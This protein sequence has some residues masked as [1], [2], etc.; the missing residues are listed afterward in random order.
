MSQTGGETMAIDLSNIRALTF[1]V[2]GTVFD[3]HH[4]VRDEVQRLA[5]E[6]AVEVNAPQFTN[7]W[8]RSMFAQLGLVRSGEL[9]W[10]NADEMH[11]AALD[12]VVPRHT[13]DLSATERDELNRV[14]HRLRV[15]PDFPDALEKLKTRYTV[16]VL[17][18]LSWSLVVDSSKANALAWDGILS[19]EFL[20]YYK[21]DKKAYLAGVRMLGIAPEQTMMVAAHHGDL[22]A[23]MAAGLRSAYVPRPGERG[24][25]NDGDLSPQDDF[26]VNATD[27]ADLVRQLVG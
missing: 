9:P 22:R 4:T 19:C 12:E 23:A 15:W 6:R 5:D 16:S 8:R 3:W 18:V 27:F 11:R 7:D 13:L 17:T 20:D 1:D 10:M 25:G 26:D 21:P 24:E 14:W 2:G